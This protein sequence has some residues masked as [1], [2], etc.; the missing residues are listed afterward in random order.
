[1][2]HRFK[3]LASILVML[4]VFVT[5][6][7]AQ[8]SPSVTV[9]DQA[10][11]NST[12]TIAEAVSNGPGWIVIHADQNNAPGPVLGQAQLSSGTNTNI[13]VTINQ[14]A[15]TPVL[16]AMLHLDTGDVGV[17]EFPGVDAPVRVNG[18][19]VAPPFN[20]TS[21]PDAGAADGSP[22]AIDLA[23]Q[24]PALPPT[25]GEILP[26][27]V[28]VLLVGGSVLVLAGVGAALMARRMA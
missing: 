18:A 12:V 10:I 25:G 26:W 3:A 20:I 19:I 11:V 21:A 13:V 22:A 8:L 28:M 9:A 4:V 14:A 15:A 16:Y 23:T 2:H 1:M 24:P 27:S 6:A 5:P 7:L 17:Y